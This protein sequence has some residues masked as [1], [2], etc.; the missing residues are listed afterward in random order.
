[1]NSD[2]K[3]QKPTMLLI[4]LAVNC[5]FIFLNLI[6][7]SCSLPLLPL[8]ICLICTTILPVIFYISAACKKTCN[9]S[10]LIILGFHVILSIAF[11]ILFYKMNLAR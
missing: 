10:L 8:Y 3:Y 6:A 11:L 7:R 9:P 4:C 1:M 2:K 5:A